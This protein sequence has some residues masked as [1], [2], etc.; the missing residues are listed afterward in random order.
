VS[1]LRAHVELEAARAA[2]IAGASAFNG[3][4]ATSLTALVVM[5][6]DAGSF[7]MPHF[8]WG[9]KA[10][11]LLSE[12]TYQIHNFEDAARN[13]QRPRHTDRNVFEEFSNN[14][15]TSINECSNTDSYSTAVA[16]FSSGRS[17]NISS[18]NISCCFKVPGTAQHHRN[19]SS[20]RCIQ[21]ENGRHGVGWHQQSKVQKP[22]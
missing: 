3:H 14:A 20:S 15:R 21:L 19:V 5:S 16:S 18:T 4:G 1:L 11:M 17:R 13:N 9:Q 22:Y 6:D 7:S 2:A 12:C 8:L 10:H